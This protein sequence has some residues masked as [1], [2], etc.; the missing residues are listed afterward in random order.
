M[1]KCPNCKARRKED[2]ECYRCGFDF[3]YPILCEQISKRFYQNA[4]QSFRNGNMSQAFDWV[5]KSI[6]Y[7]NHPQSVRLQRLLLMQKLY[8]VKEEKQ[9]ETRQTIQSA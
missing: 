3:T 4:L 7:D 5:S 6:I 8:H 9:E 2:S 1:E